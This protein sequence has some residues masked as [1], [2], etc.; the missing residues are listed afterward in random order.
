[1]A[2]MLVP[3]TPSQRLHSARRT[4]VHAEAELAD[5]HI[6]V[7]PSTTS[8]QA[9]PAARAKPS[10]RTAALNPRIPENLR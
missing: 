7:V 3:H 10:G 8:E 9:R 4:D 2:S 6:T 1:M 5:V